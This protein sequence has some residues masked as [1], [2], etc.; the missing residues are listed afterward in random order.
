MLKETH[1]LHVVQAL[2]SRGLDLIVEFVL[3]LI[4][5]DTHENRQQ[6]PHK[7]LVTPSVI[8]CT[9]SRQAHNIIVNLE[10][11]RTIQSTF[12]TVK[13]YI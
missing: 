4:T 1:Y 6:F 12:N 13:A 11:L 3:L 7:A 5:Y 8:L 10:I 9:H 2:R